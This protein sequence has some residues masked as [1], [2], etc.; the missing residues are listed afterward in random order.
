VEISSVDISNSPPVTT[1]S[2]RV[3]LDKPELSSSSQSC[4]VPRDSERRKRQKWLEDE[5]SQPHH[6]YK[7]AKSSSLSI[8]GKEKTS[9]TPQVALNSGGTGIEPLAMLKVGPYMDH[10]PVENVIEMYHNNSLDLPRDEPFTD[11]Q[12]HKEV[13]LAMVL[14]G[15]PVSCLFNNS[16]KNKFQAC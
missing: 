13:P 2:T 14:P 6:C 11:D 12:R 4:S 1:P 7:R 15:T 5:T 9:V 10:T 16:F 3:Y 8:L